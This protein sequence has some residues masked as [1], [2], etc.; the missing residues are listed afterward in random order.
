[1][2]MECFVTTGARS[3]S[4]CAT[5]G[6]AIDDAATVAPAITETNRCCMTRLLRL[7]GP[8]E[9]D[10]PLDLHL[11]SERRRQTLHFTKDL[12]GERG[13]GERRD[14]LGSWAGRVQIDR[15]DADLFQL[16]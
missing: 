16:S 7:L 9:A 1:M 12:R 14:A 13:V 15:V 5:A 10:V 11:R 4:T 2:A 6:R 8:D 3:V